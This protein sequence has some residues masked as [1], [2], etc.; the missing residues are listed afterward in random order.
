MPPAVVQTIVHVARY[1][2]DVGDALA[3]PRLSP[4]QGRS[5]EIEPGWS[6][7]VY[8]A[9]RAAGFSLRNRIADMQFGGVHAIQ[10]RKDGVLV[11]AADPRRDGVAVGY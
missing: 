4:G 9:L 6:P 10:V 2:R 5:L 1:G 3:A 11:G 7:A 8:A